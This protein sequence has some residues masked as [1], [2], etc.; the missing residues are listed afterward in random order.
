MKQ[1]AFAGA[2]YAGK[3]NQTRKELFL[4]EVGFGFLFWLTTIDDI[5][6]HREERR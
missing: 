3:R 6:Q 1:V 2:E 5:E 4:V